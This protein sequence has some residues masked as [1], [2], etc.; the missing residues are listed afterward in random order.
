[1]LNWYTQKI[2]HLLHEF[3]TDLER[4]LSSEEATAQ[5]SKYGNNPI[6]QS[7][8]S[9]LLILLLKQCTNLTVLLLFVIIC[10]LFYFQR[11]IHEILVFSAILCFHVLWRFIQAGRT[12]YQLRSIR[13]H[14]EVSV[15]V[16]RDERVLK[17]SPMAIV[18]AIC[19]S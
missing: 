14:L 18:P 12:H 11:S 19:C 10:S 4:G 3:K 17:L 7:H 6:L 2:P 8:E 15:S 9:S 1:M 5:G 13:T 16:I